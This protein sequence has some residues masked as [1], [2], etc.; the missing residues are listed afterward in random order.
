MDPPGRGHQGQGEVQ[1]GCREYLEDPLG[2]HLGDR[3]WDQG[4]SLGSPLASHVVWTED[5]YWSNIIFALKE[6]LI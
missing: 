2:G 6:R 4:K 5:G 3:L 1:S